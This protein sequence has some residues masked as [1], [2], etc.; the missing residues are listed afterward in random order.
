MFIGASETFGEPTQAN[1]DYPAQVRESLRR[2]GCYEVLNTAFPGFDVRAL[3]RYYEY[4]MSQLKPDV[5]FVYPP[6]HF[7][8]GE[9]GPRNTTPP[10]RAPTY[11]NSS[12]GILERSRFLERLRDT[13]EMPAFIQ[14]KRV[15]QW[16]EDAQRGKSADWA[17]RTIPQDRLDLFTNDLR[18]FIAL[19]RAS[20]AE[21][22]LLTH[23]VRVASPPR[24]EDLN[25]LYAMRVYV[26]R[27]TE[28]TLAGFEYAAAERTREVAAA[29]NV[30]LVDVA[31]QLSGRREL[32]IDLV[33]FTNEGHAKVA[34]LILQQMQSR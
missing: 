30:P 31:Q 21:P 12:P 5:V 25:D 2:K 19:I 18:D 1:K 10:Q 9:V 8:L 20:G 33:H 15:R 32:F 3:M 27:A 17:F 22:V 7:Y 26:P 11:P 29:T 34:Q 4:Y 24:E 13:A 23:A 16:I 14:K 28:A 6:T